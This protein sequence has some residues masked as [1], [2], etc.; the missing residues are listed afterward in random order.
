MTWWVIPLVATLAAWA[1]TRVGGS[2]R[3]RRPVRHVPG[4][5]ED[6][7]DL[8]RFARALADRMP[9]QQEAGR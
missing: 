4:S 6:R 8:E 3:H 5:P 1:W 7:A 9:H 2:W